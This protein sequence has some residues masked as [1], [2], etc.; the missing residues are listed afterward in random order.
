MWGGILSAKPFVKTLKHTRGKYG[1]SNFKVFVLK[2]G[3][4]RYLTHRVSA[5]ACASL[6]GRFE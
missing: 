2:S 3:Q 4:I 1:A 6:F 5:L